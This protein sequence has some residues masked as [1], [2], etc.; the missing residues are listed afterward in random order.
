[1][2]VIRSRPA[3]AVHSMISRTLRDGRLLFLILTLATMACSRNAPAPPAAVGGTRQ[4]DPQNAGGITGR[5]AFQGT[6]P[7]PNV[8]RMQT[9]KSCLIGDSPNPVD[10]ALLVNGSGAVQNAFVYVKAG[11]D[12]EYAFQVPAEPAVLD[13]KGCIYTPRV[14]GVMT[15]Q[16]LHVLNSDDTMH[17]VHALPRQNQEFNHGQRLKGE[18][19][20]KTFAVPEVMVRFKCDVH[21]WMA[22]YVGVM[23]HPF[24]AV[25]DAD[26]WYEIKGL[27]PGDYTLA[28]WHEKLGTQEQKISVAAKQTQTAD[29]ALSSTIGGH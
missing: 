8:L 16:P 28:I 26:G 13:Q 29:Y 18:R 19:L 7:A 15:G 1:M 4:V 2:A 12:P 10:N 20:N 6:P 27:P 5:V 9:D 14:I 23:A 17:N 25:T 22:A 21:G 3:G 24:F 11:L